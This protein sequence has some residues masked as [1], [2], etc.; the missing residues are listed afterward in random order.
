MKLRAKTD[1]QM[2]INQKDLFTL[3]LS[4]SAVERECCK[5]IPA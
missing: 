5:Q 4:I 2:K 3:L 1:A